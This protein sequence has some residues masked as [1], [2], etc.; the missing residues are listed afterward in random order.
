[1]KRLRNPPEEMAAGRVMMAAGF[2]AAIKQIC[3]YQSPS[4]VNICELFCEK[5]LLKILPSPFFLLY[6]HADPFHLS[7]SPSSRASSPRQLPIYTRSIRIE[8]S[9]APSSFSSG[10]LVRAHLFSLFSPIIFIPPSFFILL[11]F[12]SFLLF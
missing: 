11:L 2:F 5:D 4:S 10:T 7:L 1:M 9:S 12:S 8:T 3:A 6:P